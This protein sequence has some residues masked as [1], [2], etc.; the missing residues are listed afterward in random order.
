MVDGGE[1]LGFTMKD[2]KDLKVKKMNVEHRT[3][4]VECRMKGWG[5]EPRF[6]VLG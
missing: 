3:S 2:M 5:D 6:W 4:N 1:I